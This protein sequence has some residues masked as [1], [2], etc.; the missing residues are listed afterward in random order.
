MVQS[1][2]NLGRWAPSIEP[3]VSWMSGLP[4]ET[5]EDL[6][7]TFDLMDQLKSVNPKTQHFGIFVYTPFPSPVMQ[8]LPSEYVP[9]KSL[10]EWG[11]IDVFQFSPPWHSKKRIEKLHTVSAVARCAFYPQSRIKERSLAFKFAYHLINRAARFRWG[12][13]YFGFPVELKIADTV[14][15][16]FKGFL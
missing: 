4:G 10:E 15:R 8:Y 2:G 7:Q 13:R 5:D 12:H 16:K 1:V 11:S 14:A 6:A 3:Y 9:P